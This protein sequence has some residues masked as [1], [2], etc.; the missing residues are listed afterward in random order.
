[1]NIICCK[2]LTFIPRATILLKVVVLLSMFQHFYE[3]KKKRRKVNCTRQ[4]MQQKREVRHYNKY[5][6]TE[7]HLLLQYPDHPLLNQKEWSNEWLKW[8]KNIMNCHQEPYHV[9]ISKNCVPVLKDSLLFIDWNFWCSIKW[10]NWFRNL[11]SMTL[12]CCWEIRCHILPFL[13]NFICSQVG[14]SSWNKNKREFT[15]QNYIF[16]LSWTSEKK[17]LE[18]Y[19]ADWIPFFQSNGRMIQNLSYETASR[20]VP[21]TLFGIFVGRLW[22]V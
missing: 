2:S 7:K 4:V 1:M 5:F 8:N 12:Q 10:H 3:K 6:I 20:K 19:Q 15:F 11:P 17:D 14:S 18:N 16:S 13:L 21:Q 22:E 9:K